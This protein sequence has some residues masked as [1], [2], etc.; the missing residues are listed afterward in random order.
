MP[1]IKGKSPKAFEHNIKAEMKAGK[2]QPQALAIA[3][4]VKRKAPKKKAS[5]GTVESGSKD[6]NYADGG[7]AKRE[8]PYTSEGQKGWTHEKDYTAGV[9]R[10]QGGGESRAGQSLRN[11]N[12]GSMERHAGNVEGAKRAHKDVINQMRS[13]PKPKLQGLA[14]GGSVSAS[15]EKRPMPD[16]R[17][18]DSKMASQNSSRKDNAQSG[19]TDK[20]TERQAVS[21]NGR[22]VKPIARPKMVP[23]N[24]FSTRLYDEEADLQSSDRPGPYGEQPPAHDDE[25]DAKAHGKGP[26]VQDEHSTHRKPY[27]KGGQIEASDEHRPM[28]GKYEDDLL[29]LGPSEDEGAMMARSHNEEGPDRHGDEVPDM[30][31]EHSTDRK[32]YAG[33]GRIGDALDNI[34]DE[35]DLNPAH[36]KHSANDSEDQPHDEE[37]MEHHD[38]IAAAIMAKRDR[39]HAMID[40]GAMDED[41]AAHAMAE[42]GQ[43]KSEGS[44]DTHESADQADL[45]R[46]ADEDANE[47]DQMSFGAL[48]KEN[49]SESEGLDQLDSPKDSAQ[50]G[51]SEESDSE[52]DH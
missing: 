34:H 12:Y 5:G 50:H 32:P 24:A 29:D 2:P 17:Y 46:N 6:M 13:Q 36:D 49:Y 40:S 11:P 45:S 26:D 16:N 18:N 15:N 4:S 33:G 51:D 9:H 39:L 20:P 38:S 44:W 25:M 27:A 7:E 47:E 30:E 43:I 48:R 14:E 37:E 28:D 52:N 8:R 31:D 23:T 22:M 41:H 3:Y 42:G 21:N 19:W 10:E 35:L 1:L